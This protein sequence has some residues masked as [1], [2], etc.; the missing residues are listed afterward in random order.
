MAP[1]I[2]GVDKLACES[3]CFGEGAREADIGDEQF[4]GIFFAGIGH[5]R[6]FRQADGHRTVSNHRFAF[7]SDTICSQAAGDV[8]GNNE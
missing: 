4:T 6:K 3:V 8:H 2:I 7:R 5:E 1:E